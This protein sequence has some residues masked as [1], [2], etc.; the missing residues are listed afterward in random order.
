MVAT[1]KKVL[2]LTAVCEACTGVALLIVPSHVGQLLFDEQFAGVT[3]PVARMM[4]IALIALALAC[5]PGPPII[6]VL[7]YGAL[8]TLYLAYL[9]F[10]DGLVGVLL[11]PAVALHMLL[12]VLLSF[13]IVRARR[14]SS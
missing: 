7:T 6:G 12:T 1:M 13:E 14:N 11:W 9:G 4:G 2:A 10:E 8:A 3:I 5:W